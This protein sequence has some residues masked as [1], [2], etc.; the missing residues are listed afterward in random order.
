MKEDIL[1]PKESVK[2]SSLRI[3]KPI[4]ARNNA[5]LVLTASDLIL[6][7]NFVMFGF[8]IQKIARVMT[9]ITLI[10]V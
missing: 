1:L 9:L 2:K 6:K 10:L 5:K 7:E 3:V 4:K 8:C